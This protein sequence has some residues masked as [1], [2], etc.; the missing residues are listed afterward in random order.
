LPF[1]PRFRQRIRETVTGL[2]WVDDTDFDILRHVRQ[3]TMEAPGSLTQVTDLVADGMITPFDPA[4]P[5]WDIVLV[6]G[7][8]GGQVALVCRSHPS[9]VDGGDHVHLLHELYDD[10]PVPERP[11]PLEWSPCRNP[12]RVTTSSPGSWAV[13]PTRSGWLGDSARA[14]Y[15]ASARASNGHS[16]R[17]CRAS[18]A[19]SLLP[20]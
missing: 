9:Y 13:C 1:A 12:T 4:H 5:Q 3:V 19:G 10:E 7:L 14:S 11:R 17:V 8:R 20:R 15:A 2:D 18:F 6:D 16:R